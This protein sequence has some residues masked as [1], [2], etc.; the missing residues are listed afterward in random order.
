MG[1]IN[2]GEIPLMMMNIQD[3]TSTAPD[4]NVPRA[5]DVAP[6]APDPRDVD[7]NAPTQSSADLAGSSSQATGEVLNIKSIQTPKSQ[8]RGRRGAGL[9]TLASGTGNTILGG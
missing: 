4:P 8:P 6:S 1:S 9:A 7:P 3:G 2:P 5:E